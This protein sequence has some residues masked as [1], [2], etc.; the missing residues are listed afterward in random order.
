[1]LLR[2]LY[3][4]LGHYATDLQVMS[5]LAAPWH[6][7]TSWAARHTCMPLLAVVEHA[8]QQVRGTALQRN[9]AYPSAVPK[10]L[11]PRKVAQQRVHRGCMNV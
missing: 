1:M 10:L 3:K 2:L 8:L 6:L 7:N 5:T 11:S 4:R 9:W